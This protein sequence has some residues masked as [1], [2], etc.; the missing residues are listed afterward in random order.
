MVWGGVE[1]TFSLCTFW[2]VEALTRVGRL[3]EA[4]LAFEKMLGY[5]NHLGLFGEEI[6]ETG[7]PLGNFAQALTHLA[8]ITA[9]VNLDRAL[10]EEKSQSHL[11]T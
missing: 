11:L 9:A 10:N 4:R 1:G 6:S 7:S 2:L 8:L 3:E 5:V